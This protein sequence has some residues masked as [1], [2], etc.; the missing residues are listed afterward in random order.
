MLAVNGIIGAMQWQQLASDLGFIPVTGQGFN[1]GANARTA[2]AVLLGDE[3]LLAAVDS[4]VDYDPGGELANSVLSLLKP[5]AAR[6]Y[7]LRIVRGDRD[8][9]RRQFAAALFKDLATGDDLPVVGE[10]LGHPDPEVQVWGV[11]LL[12]VLAFEDEDL[13][14]GP[15]GV[16]A[17]EHTNPRVRTAYADNFP[18]GDDC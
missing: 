6:A 10:L 3:V 13:A 16:M 2:I 7:C 15:Y 8:A 12:R 14:T 17:R 1:G 9:G 5:A 4:V 11:A 18:D